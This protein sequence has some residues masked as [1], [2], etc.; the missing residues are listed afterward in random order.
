MQEAGLL[1]LQFISFPVGL[2][3]LSSMACIGFRREDDG[4]KIEDANHDQKF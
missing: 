2:A 1:N 4:G 3:R